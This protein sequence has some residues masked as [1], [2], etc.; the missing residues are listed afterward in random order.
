MSIVSA[1]QLG[2]AFN[3]Y[4]L[5][6]NLTFGIQQGQRVALVGINGAGKST[7]LKLL[8]EKITPTEEWQEA[9]KKHLDKL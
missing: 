6:K 8:A 9:V 7:L 3:D 4:W 1:E 2:H 5:F